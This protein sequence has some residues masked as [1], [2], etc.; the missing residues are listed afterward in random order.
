M[1]LL[2]LGG[3]DVRAMLSMRECMLAMRKALGAVSTGT[4]VLPLRTV[5]HLPGTLNFFAAMPGAIPGAFGAKVITVFPGNEHTPFDSHQGAVLLFDADNGS[6]LAVMD[7][8]Q[9]TAMRTAAVSGVAT[10]M[11]AR[12]DASDLAILGSGVQ[13]MSHL[14]A[15]LEARPIRRVRAWSPTESRLNEFAE[16]ASIRFGLTVESSRSARVA[17]EGAHIVCTTTASREPVLRGEWLA[18]GTHIN[19]VGASVPSARELDSNA[20]TQARMYVDRRESALAE[21]GDFLVPKSEGRVTDAHILGELG[22]L[23]LGKI[24][25]R[26]TD[27][28]I[29]LF[30]SLGLAVEDVAAAKLVFDRA[31]VGGAGTK[32]EFGGRRGASPG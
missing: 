23:L 3:A 24:K 29:T 13:A 8:S 7:A 31:T 19:A 22:D 25:G 5:V 21:A 15:M 30:K 27:E 4:A 18:P 28:Q 20:V 2:V 1:S 16:R 6:L 12:E 17:V 10:Q 14:E 9:I 11:L 32:V 26:T